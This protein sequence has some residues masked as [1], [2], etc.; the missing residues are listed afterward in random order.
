MEHIIFLIFRRMRAPLLA[1]IG[2]YSLAVLGLVLIPG[3][4]ARGNPWHMDFLHAFYFVSFMATTIGFGEIPYPFNDLQRLWVTLM[5]YATVVVWIYSIGTLIS[6]LRETAFLDALTELRF[7]RRIRRLRE[8]FYLVCGYGETGSALVRALTEHDRHA[9]AVEIDAQRVAALQLENLRHFVPVLHGDAGRSLHLLEAGLKHPSCEG[10]VALTNSNQV[11]LEIAI[12][13]KLLNPA[14]KVICRADSH[15]VELNMASF[16]TDHI[17][18]PFDLFADHLAMALH[19]PGMYL[20]HEW[21]AEL[22]QSSLANPIFPPRG[23]WVL[24]GYGRFGKAVHK[25]LTYEGIRTVVIEADPGRTSPPENSVIGRGT[26]AVTLRE[27]NIDKAVGIVAGTDDDTNN[28]SILMT[29]RA[30]NPDLFV[31]V[32][33]NRRS[34]QALFDVVNADLVMH[35]SAVIANRIR[36]LLATPML[37]DF[38][39]HARHH[40]EQWACELV[41]RIL[42]LVDERTPDVW[43]I[44]ISDEGAHAVAAAIAAGIRVRLGE[45]MTDPRERERRL[46][47]LPLLLQRGE[48]PVLLPGVETELQAGDGILFCGTPPANTRMEWTLQ[49]QHALA[50]IRTGS[51]PPQGALWRILRRRA[52]NAETGSA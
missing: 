3:S 34:N 26:E 2:T 4:D 11:N 40:K 33:Q 42:A 31:V 17:I 44:A 29:A 32:R 16:G 1:L 13:S 35:P 36:V 10:V 19:A 5:I 41:S 52:G 9:V 27:A 49:N 8:P 30:L 45:L 48:E 25:R 18:D 15:D 6:L 38:M 46:P 22:D 51:S 43:E 47:C 20:L 24:C 12:A 21:L 14:T 28:L 37:A 39:L 7:A 23:R 50:Y